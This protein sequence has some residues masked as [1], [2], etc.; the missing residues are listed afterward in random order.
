MAFV[1]SLPSG[2]GSVRCSN[3]RG[4]TSGWLVFLDYKR[5]GRNPSVLNKVLLDFQT[6]VTDGDR[7][8]SMPVD[9]FRRCNPSTRNNCHPDNCNSKDR[10]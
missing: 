3:R 8:E 10:H 2:R 9:L 7:G 1:V 4:G 6:R 5:G